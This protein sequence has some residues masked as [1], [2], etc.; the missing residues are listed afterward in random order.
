M[1]GGTSDYLCFRE[2]GTTYSSGPNINCADTLRATLK[3]GALQID[4]RKTATS[5]EPLPSRR[6]FHEWLFLATPPHLGF[7]PV[8]IV[9]GRLL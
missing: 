4:V 1:L 3:P 8:R 6:L 5:L 9:N 7:I 2:H